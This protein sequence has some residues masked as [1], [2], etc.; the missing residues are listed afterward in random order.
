MTLRWLTI[1]CLFLG[2]A[3]P[4]RAATL[5]LEQ[6]QRMVEKKPAEAPAPKD[7]PLVVNPGVVAEVNRVIKNRSAKQYFREVLQRLDGYREMMETKLERHRLPLELLAVP[8]VESGYRNLSADDESPQ[9][10]GLWM[11]VKRTA[12]H[13]GLRIGEVRDE[14]LNEEKATEAAAKYLA[15][16]YRVFHSWP[17]ALAAYN[18]GETYVKTRIAEAGTR[19]AWKLEE[20][21]ILGRYLD[22]T[23]A[24]AFLLRHPHLLD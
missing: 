7:F 17:L 13:Y 10:A 5:T 2:V 16:L 15:H 1:A 22:K 12:R 6:A 9:G 18:R 23:M 3:A 21:T 14:R 20:E 8:V 24:A 19:D 11:F 4:L